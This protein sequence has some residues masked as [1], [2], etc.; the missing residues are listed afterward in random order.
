MQGAI[1][2]A[3]KIDRMLGFGGWRY[4]YIRPIEMSTLLELVP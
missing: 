4:D 2:S 1:S 3:F